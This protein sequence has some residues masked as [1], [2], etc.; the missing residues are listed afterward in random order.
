MKIWHCYRF[1]VAKMDKE[2]TILI[3]DRNGH[4]RDFLEREMM[5]EGYKIRVAK[6]A[7]EVL[8]WVFHHD[9]IHLVVLDPDLPDSDE[10]PLLEKIN[11]RIPTLPVV[12]HAFSLETTIPPEI[13]NK[14]IFVE[15]L[16]NSIEQLK[17]VV[18]ETLG[19]SK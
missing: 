10:V 14:V 5:A 11:D 3:A 6:N 15:K 19:R 13:L 9:P 18:S 1:T 4:V 12:I 2:L 8:K 7:K 16:G 17:K